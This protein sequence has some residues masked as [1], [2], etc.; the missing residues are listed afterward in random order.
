MTSSHV[1]PA[2]DHADYGM[3]VNQPNRVE[4]LRRR[5]RALLNVCPGDVLEV[6]VYRG[7]TL[8]VLAELVRE[9]CP[10]RKL[11]AVDTFVGH[12]YTD[13]HPVHPVGKYADV[14]VAELRTML[15][16]KGLTEYVQIEQG[17][18]EEVLPRL[19]LTQVTFSHI[20]CDL[21]QPVKFC[22]SY[23]PTH[24][25]ECAVLFF[26][27]FLHDHCPDAT[28][29]IREEFGPD[30]RAI[31]LEDGTEWSC[32]I[33]LRT[34]RSDQ[35]PLI[36]LRN[37]RVP[38]VAGRL[39]LDSI[40]LE[41]ANGESLAIVGPSGAGKT[42]LLFVMAG[43]RPSDGVQR[44]ER[45]CR[46]GAIGMLFQE[47]LLFPWMT[48]SKNLDV[49]LSLHNGDPRN[50]KD[51]INR[52]LNEVG[53]GDPLF[54][55]RTPE[56]LSV[57][58]RRRVSLAGVLTRDAV[59]WLLDE[60]TS[61]LDFALKAEIQDLLHSLWGNRSSTLIVV[62]HDIEEAVFLAERIVCIR[63][64]KLV[65]EVR[66]RLPFPRDESVRRSAELAQHVADVRA[67]FATAAG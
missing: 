1:N 54:L 15:E 53:L 66:V 18:A 57:G 10:T 34:R 16:Q 38:S 24:I 26:D 41:V 19:D 17:L 11:I 46:P 20:D 60:P 27:D 62:T 9:L 42:T 56:Q 5:C 47:D 48:V 12:P 39:R 43:L 45:L 21:Y 31:R 7:G 25:R 49:I 29:A 36:Q 51:R 50:R 2:V 61:T 59:L 14:S 52:I 65:G 28:R 35:E 67:L 33:P 22:A 44:A 64:G 63:E 32:E 3:S 40:S 4:L 23:L 6:G 37:V 30:V 8:V 58:Q 55:N 13:D